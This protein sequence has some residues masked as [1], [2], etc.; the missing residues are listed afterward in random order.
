MEFARLVCRM[1]HEQFARHFSIFVNHTGRF[2]AS[3]IQR[4][5]FLRAVADVSVAYAVAKTFSG[6]NKHHPVANCPVQPCLYA[7]YGLYL[8]VQVL[9]H[10]VKPLLIAPRTPVPYFVRHGCKIPPDTNVAFSQLNSY[11]KSFQIPAPRFVA[12]AVAKYFQRC[13]ARQASRVVMRRMRTRPQTAGTVRSKQIQ[14]RLFC[15]RECA[16][17]RAASRAVFRPAVNY[18]QKKFFHDNHTV[19]TSMLLFPVRIPYTSQDFEVFTAEFSFR[20]LSAKIVKRTSPLPTGSPIFLFRRTPAPRSLGVPA[21]RQIS[22]SAAL[23]MAETVPPV[24]ERTLKLKAPTSISPGFTSGF[25]PCA[26]IISRSFFSA[27]PLFIIS[28]AIFLLPLPAILS[29]TP[30]IEVALSNTSLRCTT[31]LASVCCM[32]II[33][34]SASLASKARPT[35]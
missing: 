20:R 32:F 14:V 15:L 8:P 25:P 16:P 2:F 30:A 17:D 4:L 31:P 6:Q 11:A 28:S 5:Y 7:V 34:S 27:F 26:A 9:H 19:S 1:I 12:P 29:S 13:D 10:H 35:A 3:S 24:F 22:T 18:N 33:T 23:L 21:V